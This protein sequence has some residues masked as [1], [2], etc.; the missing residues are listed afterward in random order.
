MINI[1]SKT[2]FPPT[3]SWL[4]LE[5]PK[6]HFPSKN[7]QDVPYHDW[8]SIKYSHGASASQCYVKLKSLT[9]L[10]CRF[11]QSITWTSHNILHHNIYEMM[12][13][14]IVFSYLQTPASCRRT[15]S[16]MAASWV[17]MLRTSCWRSRRGSCQ[18]WAV[19]R[20]RRRGAPP[21]PLTTRCPPAWSSHA[22]GRM[23]S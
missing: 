1:F 6:G 9:F 18:W 3:Y 12:F 16:G 21:T 8:H 4:L 11:S 2:N 17:R 10:S 14:C 20:A 22:T 13:P 5:L 19:A 7:S 23:L 15:H